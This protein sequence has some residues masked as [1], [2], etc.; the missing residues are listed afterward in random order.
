VRAVPVAVPEDLPRSRRTSGEV[1]RLLLD[2][3]QELFAANGFRGTS[4]REI[5]NKAG[6]A[7]VLLFRN[8][9]SKADLYSAAVVLPLTRFIDEWLEVDAA[10]WRPDRAEHQQRLFMARLYDIVAEN[11]GLIMSYLGMSV[12]EPEIVTGLEHTPALDQAFDQ[13]AERSAER[14]TQLG[15]LPPADTRVVTRAVVGMV[16]MMALMRDFGLARDKDSTAR[17]KV[18][19]EMTTLVL[20]GVLHREQG[21]V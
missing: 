19:D 13:L 1:R 8:F 17:E 11:R 7:E 4:T 15:R 18:L 14:V 21:P 5:A 16:T 3:A 10:E 9:G 12:F 6:V 2:A 20:H